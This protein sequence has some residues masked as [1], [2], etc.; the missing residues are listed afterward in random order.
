VRDAVC[1]SCSVL[2]L[3]WLGVAEKQSVGIAVSRKRGVRDAV[4]GTVGGVVCGRRSV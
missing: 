3:R 2:E 1:G 4:C